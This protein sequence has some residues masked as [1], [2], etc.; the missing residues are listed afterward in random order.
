MARP[1]GPSGYP[2]GDATLPSQAMTPPHEMLRE[3]LVAA[4]RASALADHEDYL[5]QMARPVF[6]AERIEGPPRAGGSKLCGVPDLPRGQAWPEHDQGPCEFIAQIDLADVGGADA[7]LPGDGLLSVFAATHPPE[8]CF[9]QDPGYVRILYTP[10]GTRLVPT[11]PPPPSAAQRAVEEEDAADVARL[12]EERGPDAVP[13]RSYPLRASG[14]ALRFHRGIDLPRA[15]GQGAPRPIADPTDW[16]ALYVFQ[17][18]M[19][20]VVRH[21]SP[22]SRRPAD[23]HLLG[24]PGVSSLAYDPTPEGDWVPLVG[25]WSHEDLGWCWHDGDYLHAAIARPRLAAADFSAVA[26]DAG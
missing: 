1:S 22:R 16:D 12:R 6:H 15:P 3:R 10:A 21:A 20:E 11:A 8:A 13:I 9:W 23:D 18:A 5:V 24:Y 17:D 19:D 4:V 14:V 7:G 25:L 2:S 26:S